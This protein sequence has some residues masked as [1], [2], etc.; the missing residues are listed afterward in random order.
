MLGK[1]YRLRQLSFIM[2][3]IL[4]GGNSEPAISNQE[5]EFEPRILIAKTHADRISM[6][7]LQLAQPKPPR[8]PREFVT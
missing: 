1:A 6:C 8:K 7:L 2:E 5:S 3:A 4:L